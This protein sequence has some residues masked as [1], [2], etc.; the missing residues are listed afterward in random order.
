MKIF[1]AGVSC[2]G[3]T[4]IGSNLAKLLDYQFY[5]FNF[6]VEKYYGMAIERLQE[7]YQSMDMFRQK[8]SVVLRHILATDECNNA[9][10]ALPPSGL[11]GVYW[12]VVCKSPGTIIV[13]TDSAT[14]ILDRI[15]FYDKDSK[16]ID[17]KLS[18]KEKSYYFLEIIK[19]FIYYNES[20]KRADHSVSIEGLNVNDAAIKIRELLS[21]VVNE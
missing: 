4:A 21:N 16:L 3:K 14:N 13:L 15:E 8:A 2:V 9:V 10:I 18:E 17:K 6:E 5:D 11:M 12:E 20:F 7:K 1:I 19:D